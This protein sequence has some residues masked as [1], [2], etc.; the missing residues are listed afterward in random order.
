MLHQHFKTPQGGGAIR[1]YY[2]AKALIDHGHEVVVITSHNGKGYNKENFEGIEVHYLPIAY[3]NR[4]GFFKRG[5]AFIRFVFGAAR[6][7]GKFR[8]FD[9]CYTISVPLT[10]GIVARWNQ[11][12]FGM[13]YIFEVGDLW[14]DAPIQM[15]Y[16]RNSIFQW[17][18]LTLE[19][20][21]YHHAESVVGLSDSIRSAVE[22]KSTGKTVHLLPNMADCDFFMPQQKETRLEDKFNVSGKF[23]IAYIGAL[24]DANGLEYFLACA[25]V[26]QKAGLQ[27]HFILCGDGAMREPLMASASQLGLKNLL[28]LPFTNRDGVKEIMNVTDA[29]FICYKHVPILETGSPNKYFDGLAAGKMIVINFGGWIKNEIEERQC[30]ISVDAEDAEDFVRKINSF[31]SN[32]RLLYRFQKSA[33]ELGVRKYSRKLLSEAFAKLFP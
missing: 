23:V 28:I 3:D 30:G 17:I 8:A 26:S 24:G 32:Q 25:E 4:F 2:L 16:V 31:I 18:L 14:P 21:I 6:L 5:W 27:A 9:K 19:K 11:F 20:S 12:R 29:V 10:V 13:P 22:K 33:R 1:S 7:S 15:G